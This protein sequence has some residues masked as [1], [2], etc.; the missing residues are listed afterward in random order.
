[1]YDIEVADNI[2]IYIYAYMY[3]TI[4][5]II[6]IIIIS[7]RKSKHTDINLQSSINDTRVVRSGSLSSVNPDSDIESIS[8]DRL[9][10][11][12][13]VIP[14]QPVSGTNF[15]FLLIFFCT[16]TFLTGLYGNIW[17]RFFNT[18]VCNLY[19]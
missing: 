8:L 10:L 6:I 7:R 4:I 18:L 17:C 19:N 1:M 5:I 12:A 11:I 13:P 16:Y 2:Y 14:S 15:L 3:I 9:P